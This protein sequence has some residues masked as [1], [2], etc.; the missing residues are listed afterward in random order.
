MVRHLRVPV[1]LLPKYYKQ[2]IQ[3]AN[4][5][6]ICTKAV[7]FFFV[8]FCCCCC[9]F[10]CFFVVFFVVFF[11]FFFFFFVLFFYSPWSLITSGTLRKDCLSW[12]TA[13][14]LMMLLLF[15]FSLRCSYGGSAER[16]HSCTHPAPK[17]VSKFN[18]FFLRFIR[19]AVPHNQTKFFLNFVEIS[20]AF[21]D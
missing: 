3:L 12:N 7:G 2:V 9:F 14:N 18:D 6:I 16:I 21:P 1:A 19:L 13:R 4:I 17:S 10:V 5:I 20:F 8:V 11:F 15:R